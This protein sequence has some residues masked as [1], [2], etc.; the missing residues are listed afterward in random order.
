MVAPGKEV[1]KLDLKKD[2]WLAKGFVVLVKR[3]KARLAPF[4]R[5]L[6]LLNDDG[7]EDSCSETYVMLN[8]D[9]SLRP[10][11]PTYCCTVYCG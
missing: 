8:F 4:Q 2:A 6:N 5:L 9:R 7:D 3:K 1:C 10:G 11:L